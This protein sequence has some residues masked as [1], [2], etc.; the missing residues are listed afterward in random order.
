M[1]EEL[2]KG[3][4]QHE[5]IELKDRGLAAFLAWLF[6]GLGHLYQGR[7]AKAALFCVCIMGTFLYGCYLGGSSEL[8]WAR[9][10]YFS[11][12]AGDRRLPYVCQICVG[13]PALPALVQAARTAKGKEPWPAFMAPPRL[14]GGANDNR[15]PFTQHKIHNDLHRYFEM[16][17]VY[18]MVAGLLNVLAI[19]DA[20]GGPVFS[21][22]ARKED[23]DQEEE[24]DEDKGQDESRHKDDQ[25][26][27]PKHNH[28]P[29][30]MAS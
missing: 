3:D 24:K 16:G 17:T 29:P 5:S 10:V 13:L 7:F 21:Q 23:E 28:A 2:D 12:R 22:T 18:T 19:Y 1:P 6:P 11:W 25:Q 4:Q 20:W 9:V 26:D 15:P 27:K 14:G 8:G 30:E